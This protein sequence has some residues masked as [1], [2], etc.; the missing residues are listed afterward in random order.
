MRLIG[1]AVVLALSLMLAPL[2]AEAQREAKVPRIGV[3]LTGSPP[4]GNL[5][6]TMIDAFRQGL[7]DYGYVE[8]QNIAI[9]WRWAEGRSDRLPDLATELVRLRVDIIVANINPAIEA[10]Q[11][12]TS[13][14]PIV[15]MLSV[16]PVGLGFV[17]IGRASC[18]ERV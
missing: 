17:E 8:G 1:L 15:M 4:R 5:P 3:L 6:S 14:I 13:T 7:R 18:R 10:A 2:V 16:D 12:V 11:R 9:E